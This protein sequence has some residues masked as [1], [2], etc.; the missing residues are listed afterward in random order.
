MNHVRQMDLSP[1]SLPAAALLPPA[2]IEETAWDILLAL[3]SEEGSAFSL[4]KLGWVVSVPRPVLNK[5]LSLLE[6]R[7]LVT[8]TK[9]GIE[10][11]LRALLTPAGRDLID[12]YLSVTSLLQVR[13]HH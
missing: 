13:T 9:H 11:E 5:W 10:Q 3:Y 1:H 8:G 2:L 12:R 6:E 7:R 4:D